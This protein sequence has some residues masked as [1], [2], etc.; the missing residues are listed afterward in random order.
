M[1]PAVAIARQSSGGA[2]MLVMRMEGE[3]SR[4]R[5]IKSGISEEGSLSGG[6]IVANQLGL[7]EFRVPLRWL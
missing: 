6:L 5:N 3:K 1:R 4:Q 2:D 7:A